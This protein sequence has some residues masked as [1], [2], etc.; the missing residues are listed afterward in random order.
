MEIYFPVQKVFL[1]SNM[2]EVVKN[3]AGALNTSTG[4]YTVQ[5]FQLSHFCNKLS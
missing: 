1:S 5:P 2:Y 3:K 4:L